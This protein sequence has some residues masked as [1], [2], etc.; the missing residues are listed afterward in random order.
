[1]LGRE[2]NST[3]TSLGRLSAVEEGGDKNLQEGL[4]LM[5]KQVTEPEEV[6]HL[7]V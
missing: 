4:E 2:E 3:Y 1:M 6:L 5:S 7:V